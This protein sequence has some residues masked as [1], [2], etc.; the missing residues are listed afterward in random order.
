MSFSNLN[1]PAR[2]HINLYFF[3]IQTTLQLH[4][5][6]IIFSL[7]N[8]CFR[9]ICSWG[10][11]AIRLVRVISCEPVRVETESMNFLETESMNFSE[12][13]MHARIQEFSSGGVQVN[14][15][16]KSSD[17]FWFFFCYFF[18]VLSLF[19]RSRMVNF[20]ENHHFSRF[21]VGVLQLPGG[22][23]FFQGGGSNCLFPIETI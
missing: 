11:N 9:R 20:K 16:N 5:L 21:Q 15:T 1:Q 2:L 7:K 17:V 3:L 10:V 8:M 18:S 12:D 6:A 14:L 22:S 13:S 23:H 4:P 19:Y